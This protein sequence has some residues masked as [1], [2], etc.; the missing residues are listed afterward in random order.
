MDME[1]KARSKTAAGTSSKIL[2]CPESPD[3]SSLVE[4]SLLTTPVNRAKPTT[5]RSKSHDIHLNYNC[6]RCTARNVYNHGS[7]TRKQTQDLMLLK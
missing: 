5:N 4:N 1:V 2:S 7:V 3:Y 6:G